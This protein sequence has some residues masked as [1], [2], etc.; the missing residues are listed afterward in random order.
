M[1]SLNSDACLLISLRIL[2]LVVS[3]VASFHSETKDLNLESLSKLCKSV[4]S[5]SKWLA[6]ALKSL[7]TF[8]SPKSLVYSSSSLRAS[9]CSIL[10]FW[11]ASL[12]YCSLANSSDIFSWAKAAALT[13]SAVVLA[14]S[15]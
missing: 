5:I 14:F 15:P 6:N 8:S 1:A 10:A 2:F 11:T 3:S 12:L 13:C 7:V 4:A 9:A